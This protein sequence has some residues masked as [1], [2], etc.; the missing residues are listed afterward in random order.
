MNSGWRVFPQLEYLYNIISGAKRQWLYRRGFTS[1]AMEGTAKMN[2]NA[3][4]LL[5]DTESYH[6]RFGQTGRSA[7]NRHDVGWR[8]RLSAYRSG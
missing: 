1:F 2:E 5:L 8:S 6:G 3:M 7:I 4:P